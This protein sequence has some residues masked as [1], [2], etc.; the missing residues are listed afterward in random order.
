MTVD[1]EHDF[2]VKPLMQDFAALV[3][4]LDLARVPGSADE[5]RVRELHRRYPVLAFADQRLDPAEFVAFS[6]LF[7]PLE[8]DTHLTQ[9]AAPEIPELITLANY[10][11]AGKP[12]PASAG[13]GSAWHTDS[14]YKAD[15]CAHTVL[16]AL[17]VPSAGG[18]TLFA[19]MARAYDSLPA[20]VQAE[21]EGR[22]AL[23]LFGAG[24]AS[25]GVI[26]L[27]EEQKDLLPSV[28]QPVVRTHPESGRKALYVNPLHTVE[29]VGMAR[30]ESDALLDRLFAHALRPELIYHHH[31]QVGQVVIWDQR[32]TMHKAEAQYAMHERRRLLRTKIAAAA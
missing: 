7:G 17:E 28:E 3:S 12:D 9:F 10:D 15:P 21:I 24:P 30:A 8:I 2:D 27:T 23:H 16:Y 1:T 19:D 29:I 22:R 20:N 6:R 4:G 14:T 5:A 26:P 25:G 13:R 31:W 18:G 32:C 11:A